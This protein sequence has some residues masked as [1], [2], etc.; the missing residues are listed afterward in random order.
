MRAA[1][2]PSYE[3]EHVD[4]ARLES[5][6]LD[7]FALE[8]GAICL[9][10]RVSNAFADMQKRGRRPGVFTTNVVWRK[11]FASM[12]RG[13]QGSRAARQAQNARCALRSC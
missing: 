8:V 6:I 11:I 9:S 1:P 13:R 3:S 12:R 7:L 10:A 2:L 4:S 5:F